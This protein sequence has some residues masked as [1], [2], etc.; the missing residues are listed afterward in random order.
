MILTLSLY[1]CTTAPLP[2]EKTSKAQWK[3]CWSLCGK[4]DKLLAVEGKSCIC[5]G[6]YRVNSEPEKEPGEPSQPFSLF[7][8]LGFK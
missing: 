4:A 3:L 6:G 7:E 1:A 8:F 2:A 5:E